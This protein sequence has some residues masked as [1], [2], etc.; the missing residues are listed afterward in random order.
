MT[1]NQLTQKRDYASVGGAIPHDLA[2]KMVKNFHDARP[3]DAP[4]YTI[5]RNILEEIMA[6][7]GCA[8]M[9][10]Y[11]AIDEEGKQTLVYAGVDQSGKT[12]IELAAVNNDGELKKMEAKLGD[13]TDGNGFNWFG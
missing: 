4:F 12:I 5:G 9:R 7:P 2:A 11:N 13:L 10:F 6:Q 1:K 3:K 8:A